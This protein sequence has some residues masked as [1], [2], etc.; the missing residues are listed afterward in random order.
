MIVSTPSPCVRRC[1][2]NQQDVCMG[3]FRTLEEILIWSSASDSIRTEILQRCAVRKHQ[4][5]CQTP[6]I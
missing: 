2:L 4:D 6:G 3:C 1:C 5:H